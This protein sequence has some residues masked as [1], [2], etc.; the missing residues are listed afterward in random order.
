M[1]H[2][3][4][5]LPTIANYVIIAEH[6]LFLDR[7]FHN[8]R[9]SKFI[10]PRNLFSLETSIGGFR[11]SSAV[12]RSV[13][14]Y[15]TLKTRVGSKN[16]P[17]PLFVTWLLSTDAIRLV[18]ILS[19]SFFF[20]QSKNSSIRKES[21][22]IYWANTSVQFLSTTLPSQ[23]SPCFVIIIWFWAKLNIFLA[24]LRNKEWLCFIL[25]YSAV[26]GIPVNFRDLSCAP[27]VS[28]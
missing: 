3:Q 18:Y 28:R 24:Q 25:F 19:S 22:V 27:Q 26:H 15:A 17:Y 16:Y 21:K 12:N 10:D 4:F 11:G 6:K 13:G 9:D 14:T 7:P 20:Y 5:G 1:V 23:H 8:S 2:T